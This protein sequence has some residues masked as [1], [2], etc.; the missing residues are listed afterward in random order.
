MASHRRP[1]SSG[2]NLSHPHAL[3]LSHPQP[4]CRETL[5]VLLSESIQ[6]PSPPYHPHCRLPGLSHHHFP[7]ES[8]GQAPRP[9]CPH[10][11]QDGPVNTCQ[12]T[13]GS[14]LSSGFHDAEQNPESSL[15][16]L[17]KLR[18]GDLPHSRLTA[19]LLLPRTG[20]SCSV[21]TT[22]SRHLLFY[23]YI[24]CWLSLQR[25]LIRKITT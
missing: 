1:P 7:P 6:H 22:G 10:V 23:L 16:W 21:L 24:S 11:S 9:P 12:M 2:P 13:P 17:Q 19:S 18:L 15:G 8:A 14:P 20:S 25:T 4:I 5:S 3:L